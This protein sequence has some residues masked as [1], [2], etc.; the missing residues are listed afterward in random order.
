MSDY[1][2]ITDFLKNDEVS[3]SEV[4]SSDSIPMHSHEFIEMIYVCE[5]EVTHSYKGENTKLNKSSYIFIDYNQPHCLT[6]KSED[7]CIIRCLFIPE[8][9]DSALKNNYTF[10]D[11]L[12][13][14]LIGISPLTISSYKIFFDKNDEIKNELNHML[15]EFKNKEIGYTQIMRSCIIKILVLS[16]RNLNAQNRNFDAITRQMIE[17]ANKNFYKRK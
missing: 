6:K 7:L 2:T 8:F 5:G 14:Y 11:V 12:S 4:R 1:Y 3:I 13:N 17:Y 9:I 16:M 15:S 10:S